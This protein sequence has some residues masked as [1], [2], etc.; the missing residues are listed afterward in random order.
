MSTVMDARSRMSVLGAVVMSSMAKQVSAATDNN[1][2]SALRTLYD[3]TGG[4]SWTNKNGWGG[5]ADSSSDPCDDG[6]YGVTCSTSGTKK[7]QTLLLS[8]NNVKGTI[9]TQ[10]GTL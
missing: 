10:L 7:V 3:A 8:D 5:T 2:E 1:Q 6:W 4:A 9:P